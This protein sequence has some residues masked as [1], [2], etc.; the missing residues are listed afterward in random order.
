MANYIKRL[1]KE[2]EILRDNLN[3]IHEDI[4]RFLGYLNSPKFTTNP[5]EDYINTNEVHRYLVELRE[6]T[7]TETIGY[8]AENLIES[9]GP[10]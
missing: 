2:N 7:N 8:D 5:L 4:N 9:E 1:Q 6:K 3:T 10:R